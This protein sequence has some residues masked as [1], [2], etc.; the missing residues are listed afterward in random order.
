MYYCVGMHLSRMTML[1][2]FTSYLAVDLR[3]PFLNLSTFFFVSIISPAWSFGLHLPWSLDRTVQVTGSMLKS[4]SSRSGTSLNLSR[5]LPVCK[6]PSSNTPYRRR[7]G[8]RCCGMWL[9]CP[10]HR[11]RKNL[12]LEDNGPDPVILKTSSLVILSSHV[13]PSMNLGLL[14]WK[15]SWGWYVAQLS[16]PYRRM[17][18]TQAS[19]TLTWV[20]I[21]RCRFFHTGMVR[22]P[23][24]VKAFPSLIDISWSTVV[25]F[26]EV[27]SFLYIL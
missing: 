16:A 4:R 6:V 17:L 13:L 18:R 21:V 27:C 3:H 25:F 1:G 2:F 8:M 10:A 7:R 5:G 24:V 26:T 14:V 12:S 20:R 9:T 11:S 22:R 15:D 19:Y 23:Y